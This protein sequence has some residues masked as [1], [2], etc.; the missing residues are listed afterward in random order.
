MPERLLT[1]KEV[2]TWLQISRAWVHAH[3]AKERRPYLPSIKLGKSVRFRTAD[4]EG[5]L[6]ECERLSSRKG[7]AC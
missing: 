4:V 7:V 3:A 1:S 2:A 6:S 5:F